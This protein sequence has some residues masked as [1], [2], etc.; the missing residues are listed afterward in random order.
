MKLNK[1]DSH[2]LIFIFVKNRLFS[3]MVKWW[4]MWIWRDL[5]MGLVRQFDGWTW[6]SW[7]SFPTKII[8][9]QAYPTKWRVNIFWLKYLIS[10]TSPLCAVYYWN[11]CH[12][13]YCP[14][15][16][17]SQKKYRYVSLTLNPI[18]FMT[19]N[20]SNVIKFKFNTIIFHY[21]Q[22]MG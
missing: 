7:G 6:C 15:M 12:S 4:D 5:I 20:V 1:K 8:V 2:S 19:S 9:W 21:L 22:L 13:Y 11:K 3:E 18:V 17:L 14:S 16:L 10:C